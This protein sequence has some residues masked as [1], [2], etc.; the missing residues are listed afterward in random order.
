MCGYQLN[1]NENELLNKES[2]VR[3]SCMGIFWGFFNVSVLMLSDSQEFRRSTFG[4][5][6]NPLQEIANPPPLA[7]QFY[8][9]Y[10]A[11]K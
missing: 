3:A 2:D 8:G 7:K 11:N 1:E 10:R 6:I 5:G 4:P 9:D